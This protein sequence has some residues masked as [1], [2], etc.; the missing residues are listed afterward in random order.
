MCDW[1][2]GVAKLRD[3]GIAGTPLP[4]IKDGDLLAVTHS[5][6]M[7]RREGTVQVSKVKGHA[8][9]AMVDM[10]DVRH[11]DLATLRLVRLLTWADEGML[12]FEPDAT[13]ILSCS[14]C[15]NSYL[16]SLV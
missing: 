12:L 11:E 4:L 6:L 5:M 14:N 10:G 16:Q 2:R 3:K 13:G 8:T 1:L 9:Q 7:L 15:I